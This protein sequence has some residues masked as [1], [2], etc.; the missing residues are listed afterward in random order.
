MIMNVFS[1]A[2]VPLYLF[3]NWLV[4]I[5]DVLPFKA[6]FHIPLSIYV[7]KMT[8]LEILYSIGYQ[9]FWVGILFTFCSFIW[10]MAKKRLV[11][12]DG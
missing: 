3:P 1:G 10:V 12:Q 7:G 8:G 9:V 11:V 2:L 6:V 5:A 4:Q